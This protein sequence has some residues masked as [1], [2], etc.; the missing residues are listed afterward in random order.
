[1]YNIIHVA[2]YTCIHVYMSPKCMSTKLQINSRSVDVINLQRNAHLY[3][4]EVPEQTLGGIP[5]GFFIELRQGT[6]TKRGA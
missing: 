3:R 6:V 1:M 5:L 4:L 2:I